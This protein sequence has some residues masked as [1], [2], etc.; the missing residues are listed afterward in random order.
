MMRRGSSPLITILCLAVLVV[1]LALSVRHSKK[2]TSE[3]EILILKNDSLHIREIKAKKEL[4]VLQ[5]KLD[6]LLENKK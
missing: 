3:K 5:K 6:S 4:W 1:I 2:I